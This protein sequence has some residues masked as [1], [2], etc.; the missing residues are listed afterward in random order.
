MEQETI[1]ATAHTPVSDSNSNV[2]EIRKTSQ[3]I[4]NNNVL[5]APA[6]ANLLMVPLGAIAE[7]F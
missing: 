7:N 4:Q 2:G 3:K 5:I 6:E 1:Q